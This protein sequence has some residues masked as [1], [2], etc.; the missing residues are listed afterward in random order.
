MSNDAILHCKFCLFGPPASGKGTIGVFLK[1]KFECEIVTPGDIY[2]K[3][4]DEDSEL[5]QTVQIGRAHV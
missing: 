5:G 3:L 2:R 4:R 1:D